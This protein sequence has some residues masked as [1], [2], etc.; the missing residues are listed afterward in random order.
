MNEIDVMKNALQE[1]EHARHLKR[2]NQDL[3]NQL[4]GS[5][6][7][8]LKYSEKKTIFHYLKKKNYLD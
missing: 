8:L 6:Y 4:T 3:Y 5:V 2:I 1:Y 7:W